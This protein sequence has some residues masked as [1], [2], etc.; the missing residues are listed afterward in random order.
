LQDLKAE[1]AG[2]DSCVC[3]VGECE[4]GFQVEWV[5]IFKQASGRVLNRTWWL[6]DRL[7]QN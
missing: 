7:K 2:A 6:F 1:L 4:L 3:G 5:L